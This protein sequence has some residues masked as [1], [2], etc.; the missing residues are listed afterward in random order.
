MLILYAGYIFFQLKTHAKFFEDDGD[1]QEAPELLFVIAIILL[2]AVSL[3]GK[4]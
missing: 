2:I 4:K 3:L 1:D